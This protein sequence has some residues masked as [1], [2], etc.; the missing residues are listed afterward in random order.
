MP[1]ERRIQVERIAEFIKPLRVKPGSEVK[2]S[3]QFNPA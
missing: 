2:L 1:D 3:E